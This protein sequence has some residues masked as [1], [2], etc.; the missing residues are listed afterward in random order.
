MLALFLVGLHC[1][2]VVDFFI[3]IHPFDFDRNVFI[4]FTIMSSRRRNDL[5]QEIFCLCPFFF[6]SEVQ[7]K[8]SQV[9]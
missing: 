7:F 1:E 8:K 3:P 6:F 4:G 9:Y 2:P 5:Y